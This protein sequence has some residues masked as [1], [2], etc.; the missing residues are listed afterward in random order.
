MAKKEIVKKTDDPR[1]AKLNALSQAMD[2]IEKNF[3]RGAIMKLGD[4][5]E[6]NV[7]GIYSSFVC[8][9]TDF[10]S[11]VGNIHGYRYL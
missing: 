9:Y 2:R 10:S 4:D 6:S 5:S 8:N 1:A 11:Y 3:G 7:L